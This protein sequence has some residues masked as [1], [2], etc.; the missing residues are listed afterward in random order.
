[1][2]P[3]ALTF[4][5]DVTREMPARAD[6]RLDRVAVA[7][8]SLAGESRRLERLGFELPLA[9]CEAQRRYWH[10]LGAI[11]SIPAESR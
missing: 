2:K 5:S 11:L 9:R 7:L 6:E 10:F 3:A 1:V 8:A 4:A